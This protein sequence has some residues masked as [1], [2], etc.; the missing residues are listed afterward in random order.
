VARIEKS[1]KFL[2][3]GIAYEHADPAPELAAGSTERFTYGEE[4]KVIAKVPLV[5]GGTLEIH[6][7]AT[8]Y[9]RE[10]VTVEWLDDNFRHFNCW[11]PAADVRRPDEGEWQ[12]RYVPR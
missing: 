12:G 8:F 2:L 9:T 6:G 1:T 7:Y 5:G 4:A 3:G 11:T 10:W